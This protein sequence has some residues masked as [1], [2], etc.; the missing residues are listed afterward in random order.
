MESS[1]QR[2]WVSAAVYNRW[3]TVKFP[4][5]EGQSVYLSVRS[6]RFFVWKHKPLPHKS[7]RLPQICDKIWELFSNLYIK[8]VGI[9]YPPVCHEV[10]STRLPRTRSSEAEEG[11]HFLESKIDTTPTSQC[12]EMRMQCK[13]HNDNQLNWI[14]WEIIYAH[15]SSVHSIASWVQRVLKGKMIQRFWGICHDTLW[16]DGEHRGNV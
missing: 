3:S 6:C 1:H 14:Y 12:V 11:F 8:R 16:R 15:G 10:Q 2:W 13:K 4:S 7:C 9:D 5:Y